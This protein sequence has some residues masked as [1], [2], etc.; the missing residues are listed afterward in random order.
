MYSITKATPLGCVFE[1]GENKCV[2]KNNQKKVVGIVERKNGLYQLEYETK[3][4]EMKDGHG[5]TAFKKPN[6]IQLWHE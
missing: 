1:F 5:L 2:V 4:K 6:D 3:S